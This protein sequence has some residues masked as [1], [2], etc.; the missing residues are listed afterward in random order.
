MV[1]PKG[2]SESSYDI[3]LVIVTECTMESMSKFAPK[4]IGFTQGSTDSQKKFLNDLLL[5]SNAGP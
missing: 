3:I 4:R 1:N 5:V 2:R